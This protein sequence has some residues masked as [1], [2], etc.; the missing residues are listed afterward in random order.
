MNWFLKGDTNIKYLVDCKNNIWNKTHTNIFKK[1][2]DLDWDIKLFVYTIEIH[3]TSIYLLMELYFGR[4][5]T[6]LGRQWRT[7]MED[8]IARLI[9]ITEEKTNGYRP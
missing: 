6:C 3:F 7:L 1:N 5:G 2:T 8:Q 9:K 4:F